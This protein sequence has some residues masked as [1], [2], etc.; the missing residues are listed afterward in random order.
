M[1]IPFWREKARDRELDEEIQQHLRMA[2]RDRVE[3]GEP[4][5][6]AQD[7]ARREFGNVL[8]VKEVT[9]EMWGWRWLEQLGQDLQYG[10]RMLLKK[11]GFTLI[12]VITLALGIGANTAVFSVA[13]AVLLNPFPYPDHSRICYVYQNFPKIGVQ[14]RH[15]ASGPDFI[16]L[17]HHK[18]YERIAAVT[19]TLSRNLTG[20]L[21]PE[22]ISAAMVSADYFAL[23]GVNPLLGRTI[24]GTDQGPGGERVLVINH[25]LWQRRFGGK[26]EVIGQ[27]VFLDN[28]PYAIIGVMPENFFYYGRDG[29]IP[30][31]FDLNQAGGTSV[32]VRLKPGVT[33]AQ[34]NAEL[35]VM[36]RN[37][38]QALGNSQPE[39][40]GRSIYLRP[41]YQFYFKRIDRIT[42]VLLGA[43]GLVLLIACANISNLLLVRGSAR[44]RE[45]AMRAA[46][47]AGRFRIVRQLLTESIVLALL[48]GALGV[49]L[50]FLGFDFIVAMIPSDITPTGFQINFD[51][52]ILF[53]A[54][55]ISLIS[56]LLFGLWPALSISKPDL[57]K[58]LKVGWQTSAGLRHAG[59]RSLLLVFQ[60]SITLVLLVVAGL[61]VRSLI[62]LMKVDPGFNPENVLSMRL[63]I[64]PTISENGQRMAAIFQ[65][66]SER[67]RA[68]PGV[69]SVGFVSHTPIIQTIESWTVT[70]EHDVLQSGVQTES[71]ATRTISTNYL[72]VMGIRLIE[73]EGFTVVDKNDSPSVALINQAMARHFWPNES[74]VGKR[75]KLGRPDS[76]SPWMTV[77][78]VVTDSVQLELNDP[79]KPE[80]YFP[81]T[82]MAHIY[83][84]MNLIIRTEV[85]P[86]GLIG[87]IKHEIQAMYKDQP[88]YDVQTVEEMLARSISTAR[89]AMT[90]LVVFA[91]LGV[92][93]ASVGVYGVISYSVS[94]YTRE[95]GIRIAL[96][97][98]ARDVLKLV[99]AHGMMLVLIGVALGLAASFALTRMVEGLLFHVEPTDPLT[100]VMS[101]LFL[102]LVALLACWIPAR[103][104]TKVDP[105]VAIRCE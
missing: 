52:Q 47:G 43:V 44:T 46:L 64:P 41:I 24:K 50:A 87:S 9:R 14:G 91:I 25:A 30:F 3:R 27:K 39:Y 85:D 73:G 86:A 102:T 56:A 59:A 20:S 105:L 33:L 26:P 29:W 72:Q 77:K 45:I 90:L 104:A 40:I 69:R 31:P 78:G 95:F 19:R 7:S 68:V 89:F 103:R 17:T 100:F 38:E 18:F 83:R 58:A 84:R 53:G 15:G 23:L 36:A 88:V 71:I 28:E 82:Q 34:A 66:L 76:E 79:I 10:L 21:E 70:A 5:K 13:N 32:L 49:F 11:P 96:G 1:K 93:L 6:E 8:L 92:A 67:V 61:T 99:A 57:N 65:Q 4:I 42:V 55:I 16:E 63:N 98:R 48:G 54:F 80:V 22:R 74:A 94:Q 97:A 2:T 62:R 60:V 75:L 101:A 12:A 35:E 37:Q 81:H 51:W